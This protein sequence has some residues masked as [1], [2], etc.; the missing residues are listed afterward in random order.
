MLDNSLLVFRIRNMDEQIMAIRK[1][2]GQYSVTI[3]LKMAE[4]AGYRDG[5]YVIISQSKNG[6]LRIRRSGVG[7]SKEG[8]ISKA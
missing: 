1:S 6:N 5:K 4:A 2:G 8:S 3:P 7:I